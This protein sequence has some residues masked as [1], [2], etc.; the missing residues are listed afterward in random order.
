MAIVKEH[1]RL[2]EIMETA[3]TVVSQLDLDKALAVILKKAMAITKTRAGSIALY[4]AKT[5]T[6]RIHAHKGFSRGFL[7]NREWKV[8]RGGLTDRILKSR[9]LTVINNT[10]NKAF[11]TNPIAVDEGIKSLI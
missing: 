8:R 6:M 2:L 9:S 10:T 1:K 7:A 11:F 3:K 4:T 5:A